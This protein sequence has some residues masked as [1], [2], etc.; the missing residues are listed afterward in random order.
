MPSVYTSVAKTPSLY[1]T[2]WGGMKEVKKEGR[3]KRR[4][5]G[6]ERGREGDNEV[7]LGRIAHVS[8]PTTQEL[9][10]RAT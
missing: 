8:N 9:E 5:G 7:H 6:R 2:R 10:S 3:K 4:E 1:R